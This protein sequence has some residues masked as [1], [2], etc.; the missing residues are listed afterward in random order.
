M[1]VDGPPELNRNYRGNPSMLIRYP[2]V[3]GTTH[4][5]QVDCGKTFK[6]A[7]ARWYPI[8]GVKKLDA[9]ILTH[10]HA[11]AV[12]G[13]D[14]IRGIQAIRDSKVLAKSTNVWCTEKTLKVVTRAMPYLVQ[15]RESNI[16][17]VAQINFKTFLESEEFEP[18]PNGLKIRPL[19]VDHGPD[20][21]A[22][23]FLFGAEE[24]VVYLSDVSA[25]PPSTMEFIKSAPIDILIIDCLFRVRE[26][27]THMNYP[28]AMSFLRQIR[29]RRTYL[30][31]MSDDFEYY[32]MTQE[33]LQFKKNEGLDIRVGFDGLSVP[34]RLVPSHPKS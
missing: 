11:D 5:I 20:Y 2:H 17:T 24:R 4:T 33:L 12:F 16:R 18:D 10:D 1:A 8:H 32:S 6:E 27:P 23:G 21:V 22:T 34:V 19:S 13:L 14:D 29:P 15:D 31:G 9:I 26:H 25:V 7:A 28:Q 30:V 3:D